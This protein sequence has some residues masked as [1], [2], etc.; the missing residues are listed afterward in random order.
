M[1]SWILACRRMTS[2]SMSFRVRGFRTAPLRSMDLCTLGD[3]WMKNLT[4]MLVSLSIVGKA[5]EFSGKL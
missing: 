3:F 5:S 1:R 2:R 4:L